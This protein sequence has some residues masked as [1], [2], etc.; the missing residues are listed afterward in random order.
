MNNNL[1]QKRKFCINK[2][3]A[4]ISAT[5]L[6]VA[7]AAALICFAMNN[8]KS[9]T[10]SEFSSFMEAKGFSVSDKTDDDGINRG[11][12]EAVVSAI[13]SDMNVQYRSFINEKYAQDFYE[14]IRQAYISQ[15]PG[16]LKE[17]DGKNRESIRLAADFGHYFIVSRIE[18][19][20]I[21]AETY[22]SQSE[23]MNDI[24]KKI[25]Y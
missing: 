11:I 13:E 6:I 20:V 9:V 5:L 18:N 15:Y 19:T 23:E 7:L 17:K 8:P 2:K 21:V 3:V 4:V 1:T 22:N 24:I 16:D 25:G 10:S 14:G 12:T